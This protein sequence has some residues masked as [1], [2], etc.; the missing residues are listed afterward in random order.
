LLTESIV[1]RSRRSK[2][3]CHTVAVLAAFSEFDVFT[4][5]SP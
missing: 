3:A 5:S 1:E 4:G 2:T